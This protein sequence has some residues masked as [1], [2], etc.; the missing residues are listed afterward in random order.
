MASKK[1]SQKEQVIAAF[2]K[3]GGRGTLADISKTLENSGISIVRANISSILCT[4][5]EFSKDKGS[6]GVWVYKDTKI[7]KSTVAKNIKGVDNYLYILTVHDCVKHLFKGLPFKV[8]KS[9]KD[10]KIRLKGYNQS[11]PFETIHFICSYSIQPPKNRSIEDIEKIV[12]AKLRQI[13]KNDK[14]GFGII[15]LPSGNQEDWFMARNLK[16]TR[17]HIDRLVIVI[18]KIIDETVKEL[19]KSKKSDNTL[20][21]NKT[22]KRGKNS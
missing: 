10:L 5:L 22:L 14:T 19:T 1:I 8:G 15:K 11:L 9:E 3:I 2:K 6:R 17:E 12:I 21:G 20:S 16:P 18:E 7:S 13:A 4:N